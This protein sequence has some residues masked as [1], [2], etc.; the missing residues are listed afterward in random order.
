MMIA[1]FTGSFIGSTR[2]RILHRIERRNRLVV[3][4]GFIIRIGMMMM[5]SVIIEETEMMSGGG[6][7]FVGFGPR[8][9]CEQLVAAGAVVVMVVVVVMVLVVVAITD[10]R[11]E[12]A[13]SGAGGRL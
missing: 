5:R 3:V 13:D 7:P 2:V 12:G 8:A 11:G 9:T 1:H 10:G 6:E 4:V